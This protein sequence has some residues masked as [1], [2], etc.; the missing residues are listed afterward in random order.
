VEWRRATIN[1]EE[2]AAS[3]RW[4]E[5]IALAVQDLWS[6]GEHR[7]ARAKVKYTWSRASVG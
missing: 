5:C 1:N 4:P 3:G 7:S 2:H 6:R